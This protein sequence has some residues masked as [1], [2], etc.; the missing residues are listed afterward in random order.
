MKTRLFILLAFAVAAALCGCNDKESAQPAPDPEPEPEPSTET[1]AIGDYYEKGFLKG[2]V[3]QVDETGEHGYI[4]SP[5][6]IQTVWSYKNE[7]TMSGFPSEDG[8][9]NCKRIYAM[10]G[11]KEN[12]PGFLWAYDMNV[13]GLENWY[14]PSGLEMSY[15][16]KAYTGR[17]ADPTDDDTVEASARSVQPADEPPADEAGRKAWFNARITERGGT[18]LSDDIYWTSGEMGAAIAYPFDMRTGNYYID[19]SADTYKSNTYRFRA[20]SKF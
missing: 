20:I 10:T 6:E 14:V 4:L 3:F 15:L 16:F 2:I 19:A 9:V 8:M 7:E 11:W 13:M 12:Y 17:D 5:D 18:P 1:Y